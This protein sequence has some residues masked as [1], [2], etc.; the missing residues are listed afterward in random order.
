LSCALFAAFARYVRPETLFIAGIQWGMTGLLLG[1]AAGRAGA[2]RAWSLVGAVG[3]GLA[4]LAKDPLGLAGPLGAV[5]VAQALAGR[6]SPWRRWLPPAS[7]AA[8]AVVGLGWY[9]LAAAASRGFLW[10]VVVDNHL[11]NAI[12]LR[13]F[14]DEDVPLGAIEFLATTALGA[15]PWVV[16]AALAAV[17]LARRRA[18]RDPAEAPWIAL[19]VWAVGVIVLFTVL[20]FKLPHYGL[21]A[22]PA[23]ALFAARWWAERPPRSRGA[24]LAHL[25]AYTALALGA[26]GFW[27]GDGRA[28]MDL[29]LDATDVT[30]RKAAAAALPAAAPTWADFRPLFGRAAVVW[31]AA[32]AGLGLAALT[33]APRLAATVTLLAGLGT[34]PLV[35]SSL[36]AVTEARSVRG[37]AVELRARLGR[38]DL[39]VHEGPIEQS[40]ALELYA[41]RRPVLVDATRSV[42]GFGA[43]Q[44]GAAE[45]FW[46]AERLRA[47]WSGP[48]RL[49]LLTPRPPA[50]SVAGGLPSAATHLVSVRAGR[51]LYSNRPPP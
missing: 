26:A 28:V 24:A 43:T 49:W 3:L 14:P 38:A 20:P 12:R 9:A 2:R 15:F 35:A 34:V 23:I 27:A 41:G 18:W 36:A 17:T 39:L 29:M 46:T 25:A 30:A 6:L 47:E 5:A 44:P 32:A 16:P 10:Y 33:R 51:W 19:G 4:A 50:R 40:G 8:L 7:V 21:P 1:A 37:I 42:L 48:R 45:T 11:L 13:H 22:Y 31:G